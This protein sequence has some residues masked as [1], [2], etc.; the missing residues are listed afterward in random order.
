VFLNGAIASSNWRI[1]AQLSRVEAIVAVE[2]GMEL[3]GGL[4]DSTN[5]LLGR[6]VRDRVAKLDNG[7]FAGND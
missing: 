6:N 7:I 4:G 3:I 2:A 5:G 1:R